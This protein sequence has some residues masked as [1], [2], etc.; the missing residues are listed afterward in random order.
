MLHNHLFIYL[1]VSSKIKLEYSLC[2]LLI[3]CPSL[4]VT[5]CMCACVSSYYIYLCIYIHIWKFTCIY[6]HIYINMHI[7]TYTH[8]FL[9]TYKHTK[10]Q[11]TW[12][13]T[14][15]GKSSVSIEVQFLTGT[16]LRKDF[17]WTTHGSVHG[18]KSCKT[19]SSSSASSFFFFSSSEGERCDFVLT[20]PNPSPAP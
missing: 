20:L 12:R 7:H 19:S 3:T 17:F 10:V 5:F 13:D 2:I 6:T 8:V 14:L 18:F 4:S 15:A 1:V 11:S 9:V 16:V